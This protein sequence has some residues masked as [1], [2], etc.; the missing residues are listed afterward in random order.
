MNLNG[1]NIFGTITN[2]SRHGY[3]EPLRVS[4]SAKSGGGGG[5][6]GVV[7]AVLER[8]GGLDGGANRDVMSFQSS[9]K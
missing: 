6:G 7:G 9:I 5:G 1:S 2:C 8:E 4:H 3:F